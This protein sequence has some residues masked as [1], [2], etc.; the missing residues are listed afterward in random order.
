MSDI[1]PL[2][3]RSV[4]RQ[5]KAGMAIYLFV[6]VICAIPFLFLANALRVAY[7]WVRAAV[8]LRRARFT[9]SATAA[10]P[11]DVIEARAHVVT[12]TSR[13]INVQA[14]L[15]CS[16]FDHRE[17]RLY[18]SY[19]Q[20]KSTT[21][22]NYET[23]L[24]VPTYALRSGVVGDSLSTLFSDSARRMLIVWSVE[25]QVHDMEG[26]VL[27]RQ[28]QALEVP[29]GRPLEV[30]H[31]R[32]S[33]LAIDTFSSIKND[34]IL[35]WLVHLAAHD[36]FIDPRE[37]SFLYELLEDAYGITE[38]EAA[39]ERIEKELHRKLAL[40]HALLQRHVP[41]ESRLELY[42][43]VFAMAWRDGVMHQKEHEYLTD[44]LQLLGLTAN[45]VRHLEWEVVRDIARN[46]L[47]QHG[48]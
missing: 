43:L 11:G 41:L 21:P 33:L 30:D 2:D 1:E 5:G 46:S 34:M 35:N 29:A 13:P 16:L 47:R 6:A 24:I 36:G 42:R 39:D 32:M 4:A 9:L 10:E 48:T 26:T 45:E 44:T 37:R 7:R 22:D 27:L 17:H 19:R 15:A 25:F 14:R 28:L 40:D 8:T 31:E 12:R 20:M 3:A 38:R 18:S 23:P